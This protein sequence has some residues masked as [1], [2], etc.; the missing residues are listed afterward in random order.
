[1]SSTGTPN[2]TTVSHVRPKMYPECGLFY[3]NYVL[4][5]CFALHFANVSYK[6]LI[7]VLAMSWPSSAAITSPK[8]EIDDSFTFAYKNGPRTLFLC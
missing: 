4:A 6:T 7:F 3:K 1:M 8:P 2:S 5:R